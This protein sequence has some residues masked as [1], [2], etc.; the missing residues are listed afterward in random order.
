MCQRPRLCRR[1]EKISVDRRGRELL[2]ELEPLGV[3][4]LVRVP[5]GPPVDGIIDGCT[6]EQRLEYLKKRALGDEIMSGV[7]LDCADAGEV[8]DGKTRSS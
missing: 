2:L 5:R 3:A 6:G 1:A 4:A 8:L 7:I